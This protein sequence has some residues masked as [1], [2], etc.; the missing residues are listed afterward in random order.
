MNARAFLGLAAIVE[1]AAFNIAFGRLAAT[2]DYLDILRHPAAEVLAAFHAGGPALVLTW[3]GFALSALGLVPLA[4]GLA[5]HGRTPGPLA[6]SAAITGALAGLVQAIGL[7]R[8]VFAVPALASLDAGQAQ[9][10][11]VILN[12]WGGVAIGE[13]IGQLL[14]AGFLAAMA[15]LTIADGARV[16]PVLALVSAVAIVMGSGEGLALALGRD[17]G[18]L[19]LAAVAGYL[20]LSLWLV[21]EGAARLAPCVRLGRLAA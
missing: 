20:G 6:I 15:F 19:S 14:T 21:A 7:M 18:I 4:L 9:T 10:A 3:Y 8:W 2:F 16:R 11:F 13:H 1:A 17:P 12:Q 5:L